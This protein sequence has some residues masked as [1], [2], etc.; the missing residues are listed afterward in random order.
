[1]K[2]LQSSAFIAAKD[3]LALF[4]HG[5]EGRWFSPPAIMTSHLASVTFK[6]GE[7]IVHRRGGLKFQ[8]YHGNTV[9]ISWIWGF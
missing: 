2:E 9:P 5:G 6:N 3:L 4:P 7:Q 1:M 8:I